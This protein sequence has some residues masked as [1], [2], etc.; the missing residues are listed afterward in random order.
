MSWT[1]TGSVIS[2]M[3]FDSNP[4][5][6]DGYECIQYM[7]D[8]LDGKIIA[9]KKLKKLCEMIRPRIENGY[10]CW[11]YDPERAL[12][13]VRFKES[14]CC[15]PDGRPGRR[16][17]LEPFQLFADEV[18]FGF[19]DDNGFRQFRERVNI[20]ARKNSK[21]LSLDTE[22]A[23]PD[24][25]RKMAD[26]HEGDLVFGQDGK[27]SKVIR[28]SE[29][30]H[31]PMYLVTFED[32]AT[33]KASADH[34]WTVETKYSRRKAAESG[35]SSQYEVT[36]ADMADDVY[37]ERA[38][39][40]GREYRYR[41]PMN[42][43][44]EYS[45]K[46]LP[47]DPYILGVWLGDGTSSKPQLTIGDKDVDHIKDALDRAGIEY[48]CFKYPSYK[49]AA[50]RFNLGRKGNRA[51][52]NSFAE[53]LVKLDLL[54]NKHIPEI[55]LRGSVAQRLALLRGLMDTDGT[56]SKAGQCTF[57][58]KSESMVDSFVELC[59]SLGIKV[60]K[61]MK[62]GKISGRYVGD[63]YNASFF[64]DKT[65]PCFSLPRQIERLKDHLAP[66]MRNKS[67]VS[68]ERIEDEPSKCIAIDNASHLYLVG[69]HFTAT[70]NTTDRA[71]TGLYMLTKDGEG[72][73]QCY[74][75]ATSR[76]QAS[77][78]YG[79]MLRIVAQSPMLSKRLHKGNVP[80]RNQDGLMY[81]ANGGY[82]TPL[83]SQTRHLDGLNVHYAVIDEFA[84]I[85]NRDVYD[86]L[87]QATPSRDQP[88][89]DLI[90]TNGFERDNFFDDQYEYVSNLLDGKVVDDTVLPIIYEL[91]ER[92]EW[93]DESKWIKA[94]PGLGVIKKEEALRGYVNKAKQDA[95]F[96]PTVMTK[97]FN[98][99]E[100]KASAW[101][102]FEESVNKEEFDWHDM[103]FRYC[104]IGYDA[105]DTIDLTCAQALMMR[106]D[107][108]K[109]YEMS[110]YWIPEAQLDRYRKRG[111]RKNR[112]NVPYDRWIER[113][114]V[115][116]VPG[117]TIDHRVVFDWMQEL[118][119]EYD[120]YPFAL[121]Y[122]PWHLQNGPW[123]DEAARFVGKKRLEPVRFGAKTL[124]IPMKQLRS[125]Y[126]RKRIVDNNNPVNQWCRMNVGIVADKNDNIQPVKANGSTGRIDGFA[127]EL[128]A[129]I[130]LMRHSEDYAASI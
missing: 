1:Q 24:G 123:E 9:C 43:P 102:N 35:G 87:K 78:L 89:I 44:V 59:S 40:K 84:A 82:F 49:G 26:I 19:V 108:D 47:I 62:P 75:A 66:R 113:G 121:G 104:I 41:V 95:S 115:Q 11:H 65:M 77:L 99:P 31:K 46:S 6:R 32:G 106:P 96:L 91:D 117:N 39:G 14:F 71:A 17:V 85:T 7:D 98:M 107:D 55:Y 34:L 111:L 70:H 67:I 30:F 124:S 56:V 27:Q 36:T 48:A 100:N 54:N 110:M 74:S 20:I 101:L 86:L 122:D 94:N 64:C 21:A 63:Y 76:D 92:S 81:D 105:S 37:R 22:V 118:R 83:S 73:P 38:D 15:Y 128:C 103:G 28:E 130:T 61:S 42:G 60:V 12:R 72:A 53:K 129:Y 127:A 29:I 90:S 125:D 2:N 8:V 119:D 33:V 88:L 23:T 50:K 79:A 10:K 80:S 16:M 97:D 3:A 25:F 120:I 5:K 112:D 4:N 126:Q 18:C 51:H 109:I 57:T 93:T 52:L 58:Q 69:R 45:A 68:I 13:I 116:S 114:L